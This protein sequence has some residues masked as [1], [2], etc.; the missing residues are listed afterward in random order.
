[1]AATSGRADEADDT[2]E[3]VAR[4]PSHPVTTTLLGVSTAGLLFLIG[5]TWAELFSDYMPAQVEKYGDMAKHKSAAEAG[6]PSPR[7]HYEEDYGKSANVRYEVE[8]DLGLTTEG[9]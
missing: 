4:P 7:D 5:F 3:I 6:K 1:M 8:K 9:R 2:F